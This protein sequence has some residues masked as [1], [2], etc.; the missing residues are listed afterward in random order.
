MYPLIREQLSALTSALGTARRAQDR[1]ALCALVADTAQLA[2]EV[3]FDA[4]RYTEA[5]QCYTLAADAGREAGNRDLWACALVR[6]SFVSLYASRFDQALPL[7]DA[8]GRLARHGDSRLP[9]RHWVASVQAQVL[10]GMGDADGCKR[11]LE[12]ASRVQELTGTAPGGW[13]RF[14]GD[15]LAEE[16]GSAFVRLG[17][18]KPAEQALTDVLREPLSPRRR[19]SVLVDLA[20]IG[21]RCGDIDR[22]TEYGTQAVDLAGR[23]GSGYIANRLTNV[24]EHIQRFLSDH[25][26]RVMSDRIRALGV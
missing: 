22:L 9:A 26:V 14:S 12:A 7:L 19:G 21:A 3:W 24:R 23:T 6:H 10:A 13:L 25:R 2:G 16:R 11:A 4:N 1:R 18:L 5:A 8:A 15:R 20:V 17:L